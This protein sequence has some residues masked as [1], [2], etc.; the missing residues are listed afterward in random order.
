[1]IKKILLFI[2]FIFLLSFVYAESTEFNIV[3]SSGFQFSEI[4]STHQKAQ[5]VNELRQMIQNNE[6]KLNEE[7]ILMNNKQKIIYENQN[8]VHNAIYSLLSMESLIPSIGILVS[9]IARQL[10]GSVQKTIIAE[11]KIQSRGFFSRFFFGGD[12]KSAEE[13]EDELILNKERIS[14]LEE[15][16][17][18]CECLKEIK[19]IFEEQ[20]QNIKNEQIRLQEIVSSEKSSRGLFR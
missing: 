2:S 8:K 1:M 19:N 11:E 3:T 6:E 20:I 10:N 7:L 12:I 13:I 16:K 15:L 18:R 4:S 14:D 5:N 9:D 17:Q